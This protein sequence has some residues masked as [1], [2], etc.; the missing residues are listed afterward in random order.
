MGLRNSFSVLAGQE[1]VTPLR[2]EC[3]LSVATSQ[4]PCLVAENTHMLVHTLPLMASQDSLG[5]GLSRVSKAVVRVP[6]Q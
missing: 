3:L 4:A 5:G 1:A 2:H 6:L